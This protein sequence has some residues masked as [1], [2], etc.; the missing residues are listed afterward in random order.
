MQ[1][2]D[3]HTVSPER[4]SKAGAGALLVAVAIVELALDYWAAGWWQRSGALVVIA[5]GA[6]LLAHE[7]IAIV[8]PA[9]ADR[10]GTPP[11]GP[12]PVRT[13]A[14]TVASIELRRQSWRTSGPSSASSSLP[15]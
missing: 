7:A 15:A 14:A 3:V 1:S 12:W 9:L 10:P 4:V 5:F 11:V 6:A 8:R 2:P 13:H